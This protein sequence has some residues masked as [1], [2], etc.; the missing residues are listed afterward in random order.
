MCQLYLKKK[1]SFK[2]KIL[3]F[4]E[5]SRNHLGAWGHWGGRNVSWGLSIQGHVSLPSPTAATY[6]RVPWETAQYG[7]LPETLGSKQMSPVQVL[8]AVELRYPIPTSAQSPG[9]PTLS[10]GSR[11]RWRR[12]HH[13]PLRVPLTGLISWESPLG[14]QP[15]LG[16]RKALVWAWDWKWSDPRWE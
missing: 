7:C 16:P 13:N 15:W 10:Q 9:C 4:S 5:E 3:A 11:R 14:Q 8:G 2:R 1:K 12:W 6:S